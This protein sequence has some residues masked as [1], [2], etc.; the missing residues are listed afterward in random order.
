MAVNRRVKDR[1]SGEWKDGPGM[2]VRVV[3]WRDL[4]EHVAE[5]VV[6]GT[7]V[8]VAGELAYRTWQDDDGNTKSMHEVNASDV[9]VSLRWATAKVTKAARANGAAVPQDEWAAPADDEPPY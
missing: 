5:S 7:R 8:T 4:A 1:E 9:G 6:K 2:F 3:C